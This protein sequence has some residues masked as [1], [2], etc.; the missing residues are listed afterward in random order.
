MMG[1]AMAQNGPGGCNF[2]PPQMRPPRTGTNSE[3]AELMLC[4]SWLAD[5]RRMAMM[6]EVRV[7]PHLSRTIPLRRQTM[8]RK[9]G[10]QVRRV[11]DSPLHGDGARVLV[12]RLW[13]RG[14]TKAEAK[15]DEW[16][17]DVAPS[18]ELRKWYRHDPAHF[19][20][21][22]RRYHVE[23]KT[24]ERSAALTHLRQLGQERTLTLLTAARQPEISE[25]Q[26]L[27]EVLRG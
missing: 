21:F 14:L 10:V 2:F 26:V 5:A 7:D 20:E 8:V 1:D 6:E 12:D 9:T 11:Y 18:T 27:A 17:K 16:C 24:S 4:R 22:S 19:A 13:P 3:V 23:L 15:L 25:A